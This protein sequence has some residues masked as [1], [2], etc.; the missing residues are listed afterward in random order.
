MKT[1]ITYG[2]FDLFHEGHARLLERARALGDRLIVGVTTDQFAC[3]RGKLSTVDPLETRLEHV[4]ACPFVDQVIIEDHYGQKAEDIARYGV[5]VFA[6][7]D[8]WL[9]KF[10]HFRSMC[11]V[12]Y[13]PR[14]PN[15]SS[16]LLR[17]DRFPSLRLGLIGCGR[18][19]HRFMRE[20]GYLREIRVPCVYHPAPDTS[21]SL[22][23]FLETHTSVAKVRTLEKLFD[24]TDAVYIASPHATHFAYTK[25]ALEAGKHVLCEKPLTLS[26][27][28]AEILF[29]TAAKKNL[30]LMEAVKT[31]YCPGFVQLVSVVKTGLIG[32]IADV[33]SCFTKLVPPG[34]REWTDPLCGGSFAELGSYIMLPVVK[35]LGTKD[36]EYTFQSR[37]G[38]GVS[39]AYTK[40]LVRSGDRM[41]GGRCG[42]GVKSEGQLIVSG[43]KGYLV[44]ESPWWKTRDF[45]LRYEDPTVYKRFSADFE[46]DGLRY[47]IADFLYRVQGHPGREFKLTPEE[48]ICMAGILEDFLAPRRGTGA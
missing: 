3:Q 41:G 25:A 45:T 30:V 7:G 23:Q 35:L 18:I 8:D 47:E 4:R 40:L 12:V 14:T 44:C 27:R 38:P 36:L 15:V 28:E 39:D 46:G 19:A 5:D 20:A 48:S 17:N 1:V 10:D 2:V 13:L 11:Q 29:D 42:L 43:T 9:G 16:S 33:D 32:E 31:A 21:L 22:R 26:R 34:A 24:Q 6:I 37:P